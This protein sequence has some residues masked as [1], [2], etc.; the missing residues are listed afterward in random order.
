MYL[1]TE[2]KLKMYDVELY[3]FMYCLFTFNISFFSYT[4][5]LY[6]SHYSFI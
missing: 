5:R 1:I 6:A 4:C 3:F 2:L